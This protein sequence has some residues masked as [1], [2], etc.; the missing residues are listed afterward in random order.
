ML[1]HI[2]EPDRC[3][4]HILSMLHHDRFIHVGHEST[5]VKQLFHLTWRPHETEPIVANL[6]LQKNSRVDVVAVTALAILSPG[7]RAR[8]AL[9]RSSA[10]DREAT[11]IVRIFFIATIISV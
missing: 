7:T 5:R 6:R 3:V 2:W 8:T 1:L 9:V 11:G 4:E 10:E